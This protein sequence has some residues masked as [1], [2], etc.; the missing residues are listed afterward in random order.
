MWCL[1]LKWGL[2]YPAWRRNGY[3]WVHTFKVVPLLFLFFT[4][5]IILVFGPITAC[6][7]GRSFRGGR[8]FLTWR[9]S[10]GWFGGGLRFLRWGLW[11][12]R[13]RVWYNLEISLSF[14][15]IIEVWSVRRWFLSWL[16]LDHSLL[17]TLSGR[18]YNFYIYN[19]CMASF[20]IL[21]LYFF[22]RLFGARGFLFLLFI[23]KES[24]LV[25]FILI[26][27]SIGRLFVLNIFGLFRFWWCLFSIRFLTIVLESLQ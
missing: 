23:L 26:L 8:R 22:G 16:R 1:P 4:L 9:F 18:L 21:W 20:D 10:R 6:F 11:W 14:I 2:Q 12:R 24:T 19:T 13:F 3:G 17:F 27:F 25:S 15:Q 7:W 5:V